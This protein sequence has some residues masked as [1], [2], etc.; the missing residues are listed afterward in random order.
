MTIATEEG[1]TVISLP[2]GEVPNVPVQARRRV[3]ADVAWYRGLG[4]FGCLCLTNIL[5]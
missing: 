1:Y 2:I 5:S 4:S 3:S